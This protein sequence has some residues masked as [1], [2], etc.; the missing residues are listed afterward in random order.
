M[1]MNELIEDALNKEQ[2][3]LLG[4]FQDLTPEELAWRP[5]LR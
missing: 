2:E 5:V 3:C 4:T 1:T